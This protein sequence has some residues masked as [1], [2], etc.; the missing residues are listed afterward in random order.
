MPRTLALVGD[1]S[2]RSSYLPVRNEI[3]KELGQGKTTLNLCNQP[4]GTIS[5]KQ[6]SSV[7]T[8]TTNWNVVTTCT[9]S[10]NISFVLIIHVNI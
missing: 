3:P 8:M 7:T 9:V 10:S 5:G 1:E 4:Q 2:Q 6:F